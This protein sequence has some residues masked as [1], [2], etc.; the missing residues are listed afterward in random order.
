LLSL[1][2]GLLSEDDDALEDDSLDD[3]LEDDSLEDDSL[4]FLLA[5]DGPEYRSEYQPPP[6]RMKPVPPT[7]RRA[8]CAPQLGHFLIG[9]SLIRC[10]FSNSCPQASHRYS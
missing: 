7:M 6:F 10:S 3:P 5:F 4:D 8:F 1:L 2:A 9:F